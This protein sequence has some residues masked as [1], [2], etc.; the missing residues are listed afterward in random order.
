MLVPLFDNEFILN[1]C[2]AGVSLSVNFNDYN[3]DIMDSLINFLKVSSKEFYDLFVLKFELVEG[4]IERIFELVEMQIG[5]KIPYYDKDNMRMMF[6]DNCSYIR[7][8]LDGF[9][10][11]S[12]R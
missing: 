8:I 2:Y 7:Y 10:T 9:K 12:S 6:N 5:V 3:F 11:R 1:D 4:N